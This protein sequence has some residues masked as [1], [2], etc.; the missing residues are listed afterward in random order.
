MPKIS[1]Y[2]AKLDPRVRNL[3]MIVKQEN[4]RNPNRPVPSGR[5]MASFFNTILKALLIMIPKLFAYVN[6]K[7][8]AYDTH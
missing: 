3:T 8:I 2:G 7:K 4:E 5:F 6:D 1:S